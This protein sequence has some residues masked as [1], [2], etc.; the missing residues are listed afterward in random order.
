APPAFAF[1][2]T[3]LRSNF[4]CV[5]WLASFHILRCVEAGEVLANDFVRL[6]ALDALSPRIPT[7]NASL[8]VQHQNRVI[9][10]LRNQ[11]TEPLFALPQGLLGL[12]A[13]RDVT[14]DAANKEPLPCF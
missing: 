1:E 4:R 13:V 10:Y 3:S 14:Q 12:F 7:G 6:V 11:Q 2:W 5:R 9:R 8:R